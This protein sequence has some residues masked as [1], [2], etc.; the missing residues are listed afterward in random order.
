[1]LQIDAYTNE[2]GVFTISEMPE[3]TWNVSVSHYDKTLGGFGLRKKVTT[4]AGEITT[5]NVEFP[6]DDE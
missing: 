2:E 4:V 1:M 5:L 3:G 6:L